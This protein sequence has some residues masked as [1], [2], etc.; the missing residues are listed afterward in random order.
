MS[1]FSHLL[2]TQKLLNPVPGVYSIGK[3]RNTQARSIVKSNL[4]YVSKLLLVEQLIRKVLKYQQMSNPEVPPLA[5]AQC[6]LPLLYA[7]ESAV[8]PGE[9]RIH[10]LQW[11][12]SLWVEAA[13]VGRPPEMG[14]GRRS[15]GWRRCVPFH[16]CLQ[17]NCHSEDLY[18]NCCLCWCNTQGS[19]GGKALCFCSILYIVLVSAMVC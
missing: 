18:C 7:R 3:T 12:G 19:E 16:N 14:S 6:P 15:E 17:M 5:K 2:N 10:Q 8:S 4:K 1:R 9:R 11:R 13:A